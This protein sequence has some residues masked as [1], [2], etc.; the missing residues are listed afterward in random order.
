MGIHL[1]RYRS[2]RN[3]MWMAAAAA[4]TALSVLAAIALAHL[5]RL[6]AA[7]PV[8]LRQPLVSTVIIAVCLLPPLAVRAAERTSCRCRFIVKPP[9]P[10][11]MQDAR[12]CPLRSSTS[13]QIS[14]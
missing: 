6:A 2:W 4:L 7:L 9:A 14:V 1:L 10:E 12:I 13:A 3:A 5:G 8:A 11:A